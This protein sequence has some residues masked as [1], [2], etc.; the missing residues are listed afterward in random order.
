MYINICTYMHPHWKPLQLMCSCSG[1]RSS[2]TAATTITTN[3]T[4]TTTTT[5]NSEGVVILFYLLHKFKHDVFNIIHGF[6]CP[7]AWNVTQF[8]E[9]AAD[10]CVLFCISVTIAGN[11]F[12][13]C[14]CCVL[15]RGQAF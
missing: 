4:V 12:F 1:Y 9:Q 13:H 6:A 14:S 15:R 11:D 2:P 3:T 8:S 7:H 5:T 10:T